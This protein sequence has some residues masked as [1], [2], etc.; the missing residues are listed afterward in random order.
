LSRLSGFSGL[1]GLFGL[2]GHIYSFGME[3][4]PLSGMELILRQAQ[5][6]SE[7]FALERNLFGLSGLSGLFGL[8]G[9]KNIY[10]SDGRESIKRLE[11][12]PALQVWKLLLR[13]GIV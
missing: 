2:S 9:H 7:C 11:L 1:S 4:I 10:P 3:V 13:N 8:S 12:S 6:G 5:D